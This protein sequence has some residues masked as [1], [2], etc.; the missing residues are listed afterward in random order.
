MSAQIA[1]PHL[2]LLLLE[3]DLRART[4]VAAAIRKIG[5]PAVQYAIEMVVDHEPLMRERAAEMLGQL[6]CLDDDAVQSL[7]E[8]CTD[9]ETEVREA[10]P[11]FGALATSVSLCLATAAEQIA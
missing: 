11:S 8:A 2:F 9:R 4:V 7:L 10:A 3:P 6:G 5:Q 1:L